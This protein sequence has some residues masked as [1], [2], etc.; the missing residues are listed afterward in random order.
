MNYLAVDEDVINTG[1]F[2]SLDVS[3]VNEFKKRIPW[4]G[5]WNAGQ[6]P[7]KKKKPFPHPN[8]PHDL[9]G[10][11]YTWTKSIY[12]KEDRRFNNP[13]SVSFSK[14]WGLDWNLPQLVE[15]N[16]VSSGAGLSRV[17]RGSYWD[18]G[19]SFMTAGYFAAFSSDNGS[20]W[21]DFAATP[22]EIFILQTNDVTLPTSF[23]TR[24]SNCY[25]Q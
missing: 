19:V 18:S 15:D 10:H 3:D 5:D 22:N 17:L 11:L 9:H 23:C 25:C 8:G 7:T 2:G 1:R 21:V 16:S 4:T 14:S 12:F 24:D 6:G 13:P 20:S